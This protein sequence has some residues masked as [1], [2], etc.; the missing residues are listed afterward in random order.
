MRRRS[1]CLFDQRVELS[2]THTHTHTHTHTQQRGT[3][4][5]HTHFLTES[6][7]LETIR[8]KTF[9][10]PAL[11][12]INITPTLHSHS[13]L[14][15]LVGSTTSPVLTIN[16]GVPQGCVLSPFLYTLYTN[17]CLSVSLS[18]LYL[19]YSDDTAIL[20]LLSDNQSTLVYYSTVTHF[21]KWCTDNHLQ[22]N[23]NKTNEL[24]FS[25]PSPQNPTII[26][27][28]T[29]ETV[30]TFIYLGITRDS[31]LTFDQH[32]TDIKKKKKAN[33]DYQPSANLKDYT[34]HPTSCWYSIKASFNPSICTV[35]RVSLI[36]FLS[37]A[38]PNSHASQ[39]Q[40]AKIIVLPTPNLSELN[41]KSITRLANTIAQDITH[42]LNQ[43]ITPLPLGRRYRTIKFRRAGQDLSRPHWSVCP[44]LC[45][46]I[47]CHCRHC[48]YVCDL[49]LVCM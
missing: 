47:S 31:K 39:R 18:T 13:S 10:F 21:T 6:T 37:P 3:S 22:I 44:L 38:G 26:N 17:D 14:V 34:V 28:Q 35:P 7:Q 49:L 19:K 5:E 27:T 48:C 2:C 40:A 4:E 29:V 33:K 20:A 24:L 23:V 9:H 12:L 32:T 16:T 43:Y 11:T 1:V 15:D 41:N 46:H 25:P 36:C 42:P 30:D 8:K 45:C